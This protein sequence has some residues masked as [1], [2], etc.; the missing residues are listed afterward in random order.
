MHTNLHIRRWGNCTAKIGN[1]AWIYS[2]KP[3][4]RWFMAII[5][6]H[7]SPDAFTSV[8]HAHTNT[9]TP[10]PFSFL[11][12]VWSGTLFFFFFFF[13]PPRQW[14]LS[15]WKQHLASVWKRWFIISL[16]LL[17]PG[18]PPPLLTSL[19]HERSHA[20]PHSRSGWDELARMSNTY[21]P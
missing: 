5:T 19:T 1:A 21:C 8:V 15:N 9:K 11:L 13:N 14:N 3:T 7:G 18:S 20:G 16:L 12:L 2:M 6:A 10:L 17:L 4:R